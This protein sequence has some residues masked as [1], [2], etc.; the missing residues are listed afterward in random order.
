MDTCTPKILYL[1]PKD[2]VEDHV[3]DD[4]GEDEDRR[5][6]MRKRK[7]RI[8]RSM[9]MM[10]MMVMV[11]VVVMMLRM[12]MLR[13]TDPKTYRITLCTSLRSP[14]ARQHVTRAKLYGFFFRKMSQPRTAAHTLCEPAQSICMSTCRLCLEI[15]RKSAPAPRCH[16]KSDR[17][18]D[19]KTKYSCETS[20]KK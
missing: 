2:D 9:M 5:M 12:I 6:T 3:E 8:I 17:T 11:V 1:L 7:W 15:Y 13:R 4:D 18:K 10:M 16:A 14:N 19:V 20:F